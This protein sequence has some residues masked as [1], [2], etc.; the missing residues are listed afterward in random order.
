MNPDQPQQPVQ[1]EQPQKPSVVQPDFSQPV[2]YDKEG[3]P[4]YAHPPQQPM[5]QQVVVPQVVQMTRAAE[6]QM[7]HMS[8]EVLARHDESKKK[9]PSLNLSSG[10]YIINEIRRHPVG[11]LPP[12]GL[13][14]FLSVLVLGGLAYYP[15]LASEYNWPP[16]EGIILPALLTVFL[17]CLIGY[18]AVYVYL[19][20]RFFLTNESVIQEIQTSLFSRREQTVSLAN[21][22]DA[23]YR[24]HGI[25]QTLL[26]YG[27][28]RLSTEGEETTYR[29]YYVSNPKRQIAVL[30]NAVESFKNGRPVTGE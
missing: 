27:S 17:F 21:I 25:I 22:E 28:I 23:S 6:P 3:R 20:N 5:P 30:N 11:L 16:V 13:A 10:E 9:H 19:S 4:L 7:P 24:Q 8:D 2:A 1:P 15:Q 12:I 29:F 18:I 26:N 14:G